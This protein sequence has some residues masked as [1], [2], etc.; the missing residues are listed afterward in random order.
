MPTCI[1]QRIDATSISRVARNQPSYEN[2]RSSRVQWQMISQR[3]TVKPVRVDDFS[4]LFEYIFDLDMIAHFYNSQYGS[5]L[6]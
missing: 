6:S 2:F 3:H 1:R 4:A 5:T